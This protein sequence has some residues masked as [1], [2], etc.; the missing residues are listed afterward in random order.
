MRRQTLAMFGVIIALVC[1]ERLSRADEL[2]LPMDADTAQIER[3]FDHAPMAEPQS[4]RLPG[5][6]RPQPLGPGQPAP[7]PSQGRAVGA[8][9]IA[10]EV[11]SATLTDSSQVFIDRIADVLRRRGWT[12]VV[13][14]HTDSSGDPRANLD[15]SQRRALTVAYY[16]V[17]VR[18]IPTERI[19]YT[20]VGSS[21][22][23]WPDRPNAPENRRVTFLV[24]E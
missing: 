21:M 2:L 7:V 11:G 19:T 15:L 18:G 16:L 17:N 1:L 12:I 5:G 8:T 20:G 23:L 3:A 24:R 13:I 4:F 10:F 9:G 6:V 14:G 22:P